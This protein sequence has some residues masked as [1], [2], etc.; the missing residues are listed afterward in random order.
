MLTFTIWHRVLAWSCEWWIMRQLRPPSAVR[1]AALISQL[2]I[3]RLGSAGLMAGANIA[4][5]PDRPVGSHCR[6]T[7]PAGWHD[8]ISN[9]ASRTAK[10]VMILRTD[11]MIVNPRLMY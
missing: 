7:F 8:A 1:Y 11:F 5:P 2:I 6:A 4:P 3:I 9:V 10:A